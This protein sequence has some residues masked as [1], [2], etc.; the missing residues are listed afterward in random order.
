MRFD[1]RYRTYGDWRED[2]CRYCGAPAQGFDHVPPLR[3]AEAQPSWVL[4]N[5]DLRK[6]PA[7]TECNTALS[8]SI[9]FTLKERRRYLLD[10][11]RRKYKP[12]LRMPEW[13]EEELDELDPRLAEDVRHSARFSRSVKARIGRL[14]GQ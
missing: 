9:L 1:C 8:G 7:C 2:P 11:Y 3:W 5:T 14:R 6:V 10:H 4:D 12:F 13:S